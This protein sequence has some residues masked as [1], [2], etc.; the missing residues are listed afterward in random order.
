M[1]EATFKTQLQSIGCSDADIANF[2]RESAEVHHW[3]I[4]GITK[5]ARRPATK[6]SD[7][8]EIQPPSGAAGSWWFN[9]KTGRIWI[10]LR[11]G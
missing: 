2:W 8:I 6:D 9:E 10:K 4:T 1:D 11:G 7:W 3:T 5:I